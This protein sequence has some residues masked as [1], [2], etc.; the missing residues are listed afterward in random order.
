[1]RNYRNSFQGIFGWT[2]LPNFINNGTKLICKLWA[3]STWK[4]CVSTAYKE[5][6]GGN[7]SQDF[8]KPLTLNAYASR[9]Y[10]KFPWKPPKNFLKIK[11]KIALEMEIRQLEWHAGAC[12]MTTTG[13]G[14]EIKKERRHWTQKNNHC[15]KTKQKVVRGDFEKLI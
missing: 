14:R 6:R 5:E 10:L 4:T 8:H 2:L 13:T 12:L 11:K 1:M 3:S 9:C 7:Y 15:M